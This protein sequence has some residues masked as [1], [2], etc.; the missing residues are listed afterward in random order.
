MA[1]QVSFAGLRFS[2]PANWPITRTQV[3]P[4]LGAICQRTGRGICGHDSDVE[5]RPPPLAP[6]ALCPLIPPTPQPAGERGPG[7]FGVTYRAD[8]DTLPFGSL[9][10]PP[11]FDG[12][13]SNL[14]RVLDPRA[15][16]E[17]AWAHKPV[18]VSIGLAGNGMVART[19]LYSMRRA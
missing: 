14:A 17:R 19:I 11:R 5:H 16:G 15:Q 18:F 2:V 6:S 8:G 10:R 9:P 3:T 7:R 12:V 13:P 1:L 4:G